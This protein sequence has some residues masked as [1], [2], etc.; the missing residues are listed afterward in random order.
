MEALQLGTVEFS[1]QGTF[2]NFVPVLSAICLPFMYQSYAA[3]DA[4][5]DSDLAAEL[6]AEL[7]S[8]NVITLAHMQNGFRFITSNKPIEKVADLQGLK[9]RTPETPL[10]VQTFE[11]LGASPTPISFNELY[12]S[13][14]QGVVE[15]QENP[16]AH[17]VTQRF[18]EVQSCVAKSN[19]IYAEAP[20]VVSSLFFNE[21]DADTQQILRDKAYEATLYQREVSRDREEEDLKFLEEQGM[22]ITEIDYDEFYAATQSV[23]DNWAAEYGQDLYDQIKAICDEAEAA[24]AADTTSTDA[25][26]TEDAAAD[27][28]TED[29]AA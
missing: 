4:F 1:I 2:D 7:E 21:L 3:A 9:I 20:L 23:R 12:S 6:Y 11:A 19:H 13:L 15:A 29:A 10:Y 26:A 14:Q 25:A 28:T 17:I 8:M 5:L 18:Y 24:A 27:T 16:T 22:T